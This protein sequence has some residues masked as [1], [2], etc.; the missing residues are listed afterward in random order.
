MICMSYFLNTRFIHQKKIK[1]LDH[2]AKPI[3]S[4]R[5]EIYENITFIVSTAKVSRVKGKIRVVRDAHMQVHHE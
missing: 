2:Q 5:I 4:L 1:K 3:D